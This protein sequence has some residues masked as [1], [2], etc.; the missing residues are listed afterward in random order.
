VKKM[1]RILGKLLAMKLV[2]I[3]EVDKKFDSAT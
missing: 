2:T 1:S 3:P